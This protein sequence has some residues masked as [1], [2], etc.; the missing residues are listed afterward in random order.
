MFVAY[1]GGGEG[2]VAYDGGQVEENVRV[3]PAV[4]IA[5]ERAADER[6]P[7]VLTS[8]R[9]PPLRSRAGAREV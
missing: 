1:D 3:S 8:M 9:D 5:S 6:D 2:R 7:M 4:D